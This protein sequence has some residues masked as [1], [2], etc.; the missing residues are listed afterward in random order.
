M[1]FVCG[2][3]SDALGYPDMRQ[4]LSVYKPQGMTPLQVIKRLREAD[5]RYHNAP[6]TYAGRLDPMAEGVLVVLVGDAVHEKEAYISLDKTYEA[7]VVFGVGTDTHDLLGMPTVHDE[8]GHPAA[9]QLA[10]EIKNMEGI[11]EYPF[12]AYSSKPVNG[13]PLFQWAREQ[14]LDEIEI[15]KRTM[16]VHGIEVLGR[17]EMTG[18]AL[19]RNISEAIARVDGDFRQ[20]EIINRWKEVLADKKSVFSGVRIRIHCGSGTYIRTLARELGKR[21]GT[22]AVVARLVRTKVGEF[23][24]DDAIVLN[25]DDA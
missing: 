5:I 7:D 8:E 2:W 24:L 6:M 1:F 9:G 4:T 12:P 20:E 18:E 19:Q 15:P 10:S 23:R 16:R 22:D 21:L 25:R 3:V 14:R 11:F 13:K 17:Y